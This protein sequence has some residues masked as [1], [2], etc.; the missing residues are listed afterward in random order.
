MLGVFPVSDKMPAESLKTRLLMLLA[1]AIAI[2]TIQITSGA[3]SAEFDGHTDEAG[4]FVSGLLVYDYLTHLPKGNPIDWA[5]K[6]YLHYP[7]IGLGRWPPGFAIS[8]AL[9]WLVWHPSRWSSLFLV[10]TFTWMAAAIFYGLA[11]RIASIWVALA[12]CI[13]L[14]ATPAVASSYCTVMADAP[15]LLASVLVLAFTVRLMETPSKALILQTAA[16]LLLAL[17]M[18]GSALCLVPIPLLALVI[19][20]RSRTKYLLGLAIAFLLSAGAIAGLHFLNPALFLALRGISGASTLVPWQGDL[21]L[22]LIGYGFDLIAAI[23]VY[24]AVVSRRPIA[25]AAALAVVSIVFV[26][27]GLRAMQEPRHWII[28]IP[29]LLLLAL[30]SSS[31]LG[32]TRAR[33]ALLC[34]VGMAFFPFQLRRQHAEGFRTL[35]AK[36]QLPSRMLISSSGIGEGP[37]IAAITLREKR[38]ASV[39]VRATKALASMGWNGE[40]YRLLTDSS[41]KVLTRLDELGIDTVIVHEPPGTTSPPHQRLLQEAMS[42][43]DAWQPA[44]TGIASFHQWARVKPPGVPR[45][46]LEIELNSPF[47]RR[48][49]E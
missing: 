21:A 27:Y 40:G 14:I 26:S 11:R 44:Q 30:E 24:I 42:A 32:T 34:L 47:L 28:L 12:A 13:V 33:F 43:S 5:A 18:K 15:C 31:R 39:V 46:P 7:Q 10:G 6:Y 38:P 41:A 48:V 17:L 35:A 49:S 22:H 1:L 9:W 19:T 25:L 2:V 8:E 16:V 29:A 45:K 23:G 4:Q 3:Y 20:S 36:M 37:W